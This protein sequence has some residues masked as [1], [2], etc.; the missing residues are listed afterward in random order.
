MLMSSHGATDYERANLHY[1]W[2]WAHSY[3]ATI[4]TISLYLPF[5]FVTTITLHNP[6]PNPAFVCLTAV[7]P[8]H[9]VLIIMISMYMAMAMYM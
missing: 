9:Q 6:I 4:V 7:P 3:I 1:I 5:N 8:Y 2:I